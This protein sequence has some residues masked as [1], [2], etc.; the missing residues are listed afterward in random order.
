MDEILS[1]AKIGKK[2][3]AAYQLRLW[4]KTPC[5]PQCNARALEVINFSQL[6]HFL[7]N[8]EDKSKI[9]SP[10]LTLTPKL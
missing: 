4:G 2:K 5:T 1:F 7:S 9:H 6:R 8:D 3:A 10:K